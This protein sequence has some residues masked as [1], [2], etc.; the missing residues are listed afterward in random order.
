MNRI[1]IFFLAA[2]LYFPSYSQNSD[3]NI[4]SVPDS[5][6]QNANAII[7]LNQ[8]TINFQ[9][10]KEMGIVTRRIVYVMNK[11]GEVNIG[12]NTFYD[13]STRVKTLEVTIFNQ[14]GK[15][16][17]KVKK[18]D[19]K[20]QS[21]ADGF[22]VFT[23]NRMLYLDYTAIE[24]PYIVELVKEVTTSNT[25]VIKRWEP[26][27]NYSLSVLK[28]EIRI[29]KPDGLKIN[30][31]EN[32]F[33][34][35]AVKKNSDKNSLFYSIENIP[36]I[37]YEDY[38]L[39][40]EKLV[41]SVQF[42]LENF[43]FEGINGGAKNWQ[44]YGKWYYDNL[45]A[46]TE[47]LE[48][49]TQNRV[50]K[51][52][53]TEN[54]PL[55]ISKILY[56][57]IQDKSRYVSVQVGLGG[58]KPMLAKDVDRL[59]YGDCKAL[60]NYMRSLLKVAGVESYLTIISAGSNK[61]SIDS[62]FVYDDTNHMMLVIP[63]NGKNYFLECTSQVAPFNYQGKFTDNRV[64][65][66]LKPNGGEL[67]QTNDFSDFENKMVTQGNCSITGEGILN[68]EVRIQ[69]YGNQYDDRFF[70]EG[71]SK[72]DQ[73]EFYKEQF[74]HI[75]NLKINKC[76][77]VNDKEEIQFVEKLDFEAGQYANLIDGKMIFSANVFNVKKTIP[78]RY[79]KRNHPF[80]IQ[81]GYSDTDELIINLPEDYSIESKPDDQNL[82]TKFGEYKIQIEILEEKKIKFKRFLNVNRGEFPK[83]D[84]ENYRKFNEQIA[85]IDNSKIVLIKSK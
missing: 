23:D 68:G 36:A 59:G 35:F 32:N 45:I 54:N 61:K 46:G 28:D 16:I 42:N 38:S 55:T 52:I 75:D 63:Y 51:M 37:R 13:K 17:K 79:R 30:S 31:K 85:K 43:F 22:S 40:L 21:V 27:T 83:D 19:F 48:E 14:F 60:S 73:N 4:L 39:S 62:D 65:L 7:K 12:A 53:G 76:S 25:A 29:T 47:S 70:L 56:K 66:L 11:N 34:N 6:K 77:F 80:L 1:L 26:I 78:K 49:E 9:S 15:E 41:P 20:D 67:I 3:L 82:I 81:R 50:K 71:K 24:Y 18:K 84:Y 33:N 57:Y 2:L 8:T 44:E 69:T 10:E 72:E 5:L 64:A 74:N 58:W